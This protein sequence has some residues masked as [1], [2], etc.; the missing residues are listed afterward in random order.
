MKRW[1]LLV[2][3]FII[4]LSGISMAGGPEGVS[5]SGQD[6][7][8][9]GNSC[10]TFSWSGVDG[11]GPYTIEVYEMTV[12]SILSRNEMA[13]MIDPLIS[14]ELGT[15][16]SWTLSGGECLRD[17]ARYVWY[18]GVR[19]QDS[20]EEGEVIWSDAKVFEVNLLADSE[21]VEAVKET[22]AGYLTNEWKNTESYIKVKE[23]ITKDVT[24]S[25]SKGAEIQGTIGIMSLEGSTNTLFGKYAGYNLG[26]LGNDDDDYA[27][28]IGA[29]AGYNTQDGTSSNTFVGYGAGYSN[30][31]GNLNTFIGRSA[32]YYNTTGYANTFMGRSAGYKNT[33]GNLNT[34]MGNL[35]GYYN[36]T[37]YSNTFMGYWAGYSNTTGSGNVFLGYSAGYY[38]TG[39]N[40]LYIDN[41]STSTPLIY[42]DFSTDTLTV[43]GKLG[44]GTTAPQYKIDLAGGSITVNGNDT[45][46]GTGS[47]QQ[48][49]MV[50]WIE[51]GRMIMGYGGAGGGNLELYSKGHA[52]RKGEFYFVYG[53]GST[54]GKVMF[55]HYNGS[56]WSTKLSILYN[57]NVGLGVENPTYP[58]HH[59]S[60]AHLTAGGV[61]TNASSRE[62]KDKIEELGIGEALEA[63]RGLAP[64]KFNYKTDPEERHVGFIAEDVPE[65][66]ATKDRK[67]LSPMD[68]VAVLTRVVKEQEGEINK[69][70]KKVVE[71][72][73][74]NQAIK[75]EL[76]DRIIA[77]ERQ[78]RLMQSV[79]S[80]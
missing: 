78:L 52:S 39:S 33:T 60:G 67:S 74:E 62:Y 73:A 25:L 45:S 27:T 18:V 20:S 79:A 65:L 40:K 63:L 75:A 35:A 43:N 30:T 80:R 46:A 7:A 11:A 5:P 77:L 58:L 26:N 51:T 31:T 12:G 61:W 66:V 54:I 59:S 47:G 13:S 70:N 50:V 42:G 15:S 8:V 23:E 14:K 1:V 68:I 16:L 9:V 38:E 64:V 72:E 4:S 32:G 41:S 21:T 19:I 55:A 53:G 10:P 2:A 3:G 48:R 28:F 6:V 36:T 69:L 44:I 37:G 49:P 57:G 76:K 17:G 24:L 56:G 29:Y 71:L 22:V 34:I